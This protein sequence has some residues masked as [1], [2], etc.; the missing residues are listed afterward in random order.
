MLPRESKKKGSAWWFPASVAAAIVLIFGAVWL[1]NKPVTNTEK[2]GKTNKER[3]EA[4]SYTKNP[5]TKE[6]ESLSDNQA[7]A[8]LEN[9]GISSSARPVKN[10]TEIN[11]EAQVS[12]T[13]HPGEYYSNPSPKQIGLNVPF[14]YPRL[15]QPFKGIVTQ[16][17]ASLLMENVPIDKLKFPLAS[18]IKPA[19]GESA[20]LRENNNSRLSLG[21]AVSP[22]INSVSG[23][24]T[25]KI[26]QSLG[27]NANYRI[28]PKLSISSGI[29]YSIKLYSAKPEQYEAP[30]AYSNAAK[31]AESIDAD[32]RVLDV[33]VNLN[34]SLARSSKQT[35][36]VS[37]GLS[38]YFMLKEKY[39]MIAGRS[40]TGYPSY[41]NRKY[42]YTQKNRHL[43]SVLN[44]SAG[45]S[46]PLNRQTSLVIE[47]YARLPI[48]GIG[49]G[50]VNL[51]SAGLNFQLQYNF[52]K[53][54]KPKATSV[55]A[56]Q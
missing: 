14:E 43:F 48:T 36:F 7:D 40:Q 19:T 47:P 4:N 55:V 45:I 27:L 11:S 50:K 32:C 53:K 20:D 42:E 49:E 26:G 3:S 38:S 29:A 17:T 44:L 31:Y 23:F 1:L 8:L 25:G 46:K 37:A 5:S 22:D 51:K 15:T 24:T 52:G 21:L 2:L 6:A 41:P 10:K 28:S 39:T 56:A 13:D 54:D 12:N 35:M 9:D 18:S 33:P 16:N 30:W 34:Y